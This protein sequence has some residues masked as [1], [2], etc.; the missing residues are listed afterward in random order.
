[1]DSVARRHTSIEPRPAAQNAR[2]V[3]HNARH[4]WARG[5]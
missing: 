2:R 3:P 1:V 5:C 4:R